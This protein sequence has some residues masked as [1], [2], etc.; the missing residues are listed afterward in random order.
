[1]ATSN[2]YK[3][4]AKLYYA[5][6][7][8]ADVDFIKFKLSEMG[9]K[10][11]DEFR[12]NVR[13]IAEKEVGCDMVWGVIKVIV[14]AGYYDGANIDWEA[15]YMDY[16]GKEF[17]LNDF[18]DGYYDYLLEYD[19]KELAKKLN[20]EQKETK[21]I[22]KKEINLLEK[23]LKRITTPLKLSYVFSNGE[24]FYERVK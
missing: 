4:N 16:E 9:Y 6:E 23:T 5:I 1:M 8:E 22:L 24:T 15:Y 3:K 7:D 17:G 21:K 18:K 20:K 2:F 12:N 14:R 11:I 19:E 10:T 13:F